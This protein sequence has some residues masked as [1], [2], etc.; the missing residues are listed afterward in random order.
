[1]PAPQCPPEPIGFC[2]V[3]LS[4]VA[5]QVRGPTDGPLADIAGTLARLDD[6]LLGPDRRGE[7]VVLVVPT[8]TSRGAGMNFLALADSA[9]RAAALQEQA[10]RAT[11]A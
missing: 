4:S 1:M 11:A 3:M 10:Q 5:F 7:G 6:L 2:A 8:L 9:A